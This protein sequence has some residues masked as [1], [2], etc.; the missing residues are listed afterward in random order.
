MEFWLCAT[1]NRNELPQ[2]LEDKNTE[3]D[4]ESLSSIIQA[5]NNKSFKCLARS[6]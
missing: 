6:V 2:F 3:I 1:E 5:V 4:S